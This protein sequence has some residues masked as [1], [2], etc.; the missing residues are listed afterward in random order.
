MA[1]ENTLSSFVDQQWADLHHSRIQE[2]T[3]LGVVTGAHIGLL[4]LAFLLVRINLDIP[5]P[6]VV[7]LGST[8]AAL[9]SLFGAL[10]TCRHRRLMQIKIQWIQE[11]EKQLGLVKTTENPKGIVPDAEAEDLAAAV[12]WKGLAFPRVLSTSW[13]ILCFYTLLLVLDVL[14][15][16]A[17]A[18]VGTSAFPV[19]L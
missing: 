4:Q 1:S 11:A 2:W 18:F 9:F 19:P 13:L 17:F 8:I 3:A 5:L 6:L 10:M 16:I 12:T 14:A 7:A 15:F